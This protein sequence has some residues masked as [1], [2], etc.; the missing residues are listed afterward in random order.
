[1]YPTT[2]VFIMVEPDNASVYNPILGK[3]RYLEM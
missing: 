2:F 1:M 3:C